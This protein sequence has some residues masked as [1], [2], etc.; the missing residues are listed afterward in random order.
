MVVTVLESWQDDRGN[1]IVFDGSV[2]TNVRIKFT[3]SNNILRIGSPFRIARLAVDFDCDNG[4]CEIGPS[5][6]VP[7]LMAA[8]RVGDGATVRLGRDVSTTTTVA[9]SAAERST[10]TIGDDVMMA[11]DVQIRADDGHPIFDVRSGRRVNMP[12]PIRIGNHVWLGFQS[13]VLGGAVIGDGSVI[14]M[15][16]IVTRPIP[17]NVIAA[18]VPA[19]VVK[20]DIAWE[21][22]HLTLTKPWV[23]ED[24]SV[25]KRS[26]AYW[27]LT[28]DEPE[29]LT[30][31]P[32]RAER[33]SRAASLL[34]K[35]R[36]ALSSALPRG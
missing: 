32:E 22:P 16:S 9:L 2:T 7:A 20:R 31:V 5:H 3:G 8:I 19:R 36:R 6:G 33:E 25:L 29:N 13:C 28:A 15:R 23:K 4:I 11:A 18:G 17:N 35:A 27:N 10:I 21:R 12:K 34:L 1:Q 26:T 24:A 14:G 30:S